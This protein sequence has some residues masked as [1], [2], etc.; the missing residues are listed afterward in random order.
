MDHRVQRIFSKST[1][2]DDAQWIRGGN[3]VVHVSSRAF[4]PHFLYFYFNWTNPHKTMVAKHSKQIVKPKHGS[5]S[6]FR[7]HTLTRTQ[8]LKNT[9]MEMVSN[10]LN[11][12]NRNKTAIKN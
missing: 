12:M 5:S 6:P 10:R 7:M 3:V 4:L 9:E 1:L 2:F 8:V 11:R